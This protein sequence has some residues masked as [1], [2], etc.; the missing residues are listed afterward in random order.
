MNAPRHATLRPG[1]IV[2]CAALLTLA[3]CGGDCDVPPPLVA[4]PTATPLPTTPTATAAAETIVNVTLQEFSVT[5]DRTSAPPGAVRFVVQNEGTEPHEFLVVST[6]LP[7]DGL[8]TEEDGSYEEDGPGTDLLAEIEPFAPDGGEHVLILTLE[9][10][11]YVVLCNLVE[12]E[13]DEPEAHYSLGM[14]AGFTVE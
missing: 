2:A 7:P 1:L 14:F 5:L 10:G 11:N 12:F 8:P 13:D 9:A 4:T 3:S 6:D